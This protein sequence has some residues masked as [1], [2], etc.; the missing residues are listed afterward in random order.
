MNHHEEPPLTITALIDID[1]RWSLAET[2]MADGSTLF[3]L[4][5]RNADTNTVLL[6]A[7]DV[8]HEQLGPLPARYRLEDA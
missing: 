8:A 2:L 4:A 7:L 3:V 6:D 1:D 5:D